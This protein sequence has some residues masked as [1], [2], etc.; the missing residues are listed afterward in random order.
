MKII[1]EVTEKLPDSEWVAKRFQPEWSGIL[2]VDGKMVKVFDSLEPKLSRDSSFT[3]QQRK[4][5]HWKA[6][7]CGIDSGTGDLPHYDLADEETKIDLIFFFQKLKKIGY[8]LKVL[9]SD[10]NEDIVNAARK[11]Y[12]KDILFQLCTRHFIEGL[13]KK[14]SKNKLEKDELTMELIIRIQSII[15]TKDLATAG[16]RLAKLKEVKDEKFKKKF[17]QDAIEDFKKHA[18]N[19][20]TYLQ[21]PEL[22]IPHTNNEIENL[23]KQLSLRLKSLGRFQH[24]RYA[25]DYLKAWALLRRFTPFTDCRGERKYRNKHAPL[26]LAGCDISGVDPV[27]IPK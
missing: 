9:V 6:W 4:M 3:E 7:L 17:H 20:T 10:G 12:G 26:Q 5:M 27:K 11:V 15:E 19:L 13:K 25:R 14:A 1:H 16:D 24:W 2:V 23:F 8:N 21:H 18:D 22:K